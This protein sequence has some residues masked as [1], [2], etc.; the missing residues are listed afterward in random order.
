MKKT[1]YLICSL[2]LASMLQGCVL[3]VVAVGAAA[4]GAVIAADRRS[5]QNISEDHKVDYSLNQQIQSNDE[6][7]HKSHIVVVS[8]NRVVLLVGQVPSQEL[9][10]QVEQWAHDQPNVRRVFNQLK[11]GAPTSF[12][13]RSKDSGITANVKTRLMATTNVSARQVKVVT[14]DGIVYLM[15]VMTRDQAAVAAQVARN[16]TGVQGVVKLIEYV[17]A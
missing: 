4:G 11:V 6:L 16:S 2:L 3:G 10:S 1:I 17:N 15:G 13:R 7:V 9:S 14:E 8:Y 12:S 5:F